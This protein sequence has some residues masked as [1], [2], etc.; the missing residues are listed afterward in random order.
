MEINF[1]FDG[2]NFDSPSHQAEQEVH[3]VITEL[4]RLQGEYFQRTQTKCMKI[5]RIAG[6]NYYG[7]QFGSNN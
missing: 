5:I 6:S 3:R 4:I 1:G 7:F 2:A